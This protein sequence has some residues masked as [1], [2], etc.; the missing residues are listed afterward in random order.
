MGST[1]V[2]RT[3]FSRF[4]TVSA[5]VVIVIAAGYSLFDGGPVV[6]WQTV[7][8]LAVAAG[9]I[10][11]L[12]GNPRVEVSDGGVTVVNIVRQVHVPWPTLLEVD[13]HWALSVQTTH[14]KFSSWAIPATS[15]T[16][17]RVSNRRTDADPA[18]RSLE[19]GVNANSVAL[20]IGDRLEALTQ[21]GH[22]GQRTIGTVEPRVRWNIREL[23]VLGATATIVVSLLV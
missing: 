7:P 9:V 12:F 10:W 2:F 8:F 13:T 23:L 3:A 15:G 1:H 5:A 20:V 14:G 11:V 18:V 6:L 17:L 16:S 21:A 19:T 4:L 22:L